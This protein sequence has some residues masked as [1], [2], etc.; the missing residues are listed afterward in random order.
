MP[1]QVF[2][3]NN[4][5]MTELLAGSI[6]YWRLTHSDPTFS[7]VLL[8]VSLESLISS[9]INIYFSIISLHLCLLLFLPYIAKSFRSVEP[10]G[11]PSITVKVTLFKGDYRK[12]LAHTTHCSRRRGRTHDGE[13]K[14]ETC[15]DWMVVCLLAWVSPSRL[16]YGWCLYEQITTCWSSAAVSP[17][18]GKSWSPSRSTQPSPN[19]LSPT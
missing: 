8:Y 6:P 18:I 11:F 10:L 3:V 19:E 16:K 14:N 1:E 9:H 4:R 5:M 15:R 12:R 7:W 13:K 2:M 17:T